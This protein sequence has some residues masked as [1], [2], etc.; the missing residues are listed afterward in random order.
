[1]LRV[2]RALL[3]GVVVAG[4]SYTPPTDIDSPADSPQPSCVEPPSG[5]VS[6]WD[7]EVLGLDI[8]TGR[9]AGAIGAPTLG[10]G[11]VGKAARFGATDVLVVN[12]PP[13]PA[14]FTIE[15]WVFLELGLPGDWIGFYGR[16]TEASFTAFNDRLAFWDGT[17]GGLSGNL[18]VA[19]TSLVGAWHHLAIT[20]DGTTIR[21]YVDGVLEGMQLP[22][23]VVA[24]PSKPSAIGG[25]LTGDGND[26][27][28]D[29]FVGS[30]DELTIY[31][32]ALANSEV[33]TIA[34]A[35]AGKC[36]P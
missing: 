5:I 17:F 30:I 22:P 31:N 27:L 13:T 16:F 12:D 7:G 32:R 35:A 36:K 14:Q 10:D 34:M 1:M 19:A 6:W 3:C 2:W 29:P 26:Q 4:C 20:W 9:T 24:L 15:G 25:L 11:I 33:A 18:A 28:E 21:S 23:G 8:S